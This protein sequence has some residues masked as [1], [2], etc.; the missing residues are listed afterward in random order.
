MP[1]W[2]NSN[3]LMEYFFYFKNGTNHDFTIKS[4]KLLLIADFFENEQLIKVLITYDI[5]PKLEQNTA[6]CFL[7]DSYQ[8]Y[9]NGIDQNEHWFELFFESMNYCSKNLLYYITNE[10]TSRKLIKM[11]KKI[12]EELVE[13]YLAF[14]ILNNYQ[15]TD[16]LEENTNTISKSNFEL[17]IKFIS[18]VRNTSNFYE[19]LMNEFLFL[20]SQDTI[21]EI[22]TLVKPTFEFNL[23][24][25]EIENYYNEFPLIINYE[26]Q[27]I[28]FIIFYKKTDD[29]LNI[30][31]KIQNNQIT[32]KNN[33]I[34]VLNKM[35]LFKILTYSFFIKLNNDPQKS[36]YVIK[37]VNYSKT[38]YSIYRIN[39]FSNY[40]NNNVERNDNLEKIANIK[41]Y[42]KTCFIHSA[43]CTNL[44]NNFQLLYNNELISNLNRN[45][46][47]CV[48]K[49]NFNS[50]INPDFLLI[51]L[52]NWRK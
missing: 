13:K 20:S 3:D 4:R 37:S 26:K 22:S 19:L 38:T 48:I 7:E 47:Q 24:S 14:L 28:T 39:N 43:L 36:D 17:I 33:T 12:L 11:N 10:E 34:P 42:I 5:I 44:L 46:V 27:I 1:Q 25:N 8:K 49:H 35:L 15:F 52:M 18:Q 32:N 40:V 45:L 2:I 50:K 51:F 29:S 23:L 31:F 16:E 6:L 41:I 30:S 21:N 9:S